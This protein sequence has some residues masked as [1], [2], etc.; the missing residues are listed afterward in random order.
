MNGVGL[1]VDFDTQFAA[2][3]IGAQ[4]FTGKLEEGGLGPA[5]DELDGVSALISPGPLL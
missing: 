3:G 2:G 1:A 4:G 5:G